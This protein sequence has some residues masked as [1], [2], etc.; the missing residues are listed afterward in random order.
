MVTRGRQLGITQSISVPIPS[1][2][3]L[4]DASS[5][6]IF[7]PLRPFNLLHF[8]YALPL[9]LT[10]LA[11]NHRARCVHDGPVQ[12]AQAALEVLRCGAR[13]LGGDQERR[14][15]RMVVWLNK[16]DDC[17]LAK[18]VWQNRIHVPIAI[19]ADQESEVTRL[20]SMKQGRI[21]QSL[22]SSSC[23]H[24]SQNLNFRT[25]ILAVL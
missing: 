21:A 16:R 11:D 14:W 3:S 22:W 13:G 8:S 18:N 17:R 24:A 1:P 19:G 23:S 5:L 9:R 25:E 10:S 20:R 2:L 4:L 15:G 12:Q 7:P 6:F